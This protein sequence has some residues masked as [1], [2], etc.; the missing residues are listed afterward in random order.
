MENRHRSY[1][2]LIKC[3]VRTILPN[4]TLKKKGPIDVNPKIMNR[5][6]LTEKNVVFEFSVKYIL[7]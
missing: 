6:L 5:F 2:R 4:F 1:D 7:Y 3:T